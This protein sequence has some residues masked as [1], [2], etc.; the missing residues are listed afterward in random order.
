MIEVEERDERRVLP[1]DLDPLQ[2][3]FG[4]DED[5]RLLGLDVDDGRRRVDLDDRRP[6][7]RRGQ[8]LT[9]P[10]D[11]RSQHAQLR[12]AAMRAHVGSGFG[13]RADGRRRVRRL[14]PNRRAVAVPAHELQAGRAHEQSHP[15]AAVE[16]TD[17]GGSGRVRLVQGACEPLREQSGGRWLLAPVDDFSN[18]SLPLSSTGSVSIAWSQRQRRR[19]DQRRADA[20]ERTGEDE[21]GR[22]AG[23]RRGS[24][25]GAEDRQPDARAPL[26]PKRSPRLPAVSSRPANTSV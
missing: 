16:H 14:I 24:G 12:P 3:R 15:T 13:N 8:L 10:R 26:R 6:R 7:Q 21:L 11:T 23:E 1:A 9:H 20:H 22:R 25:T 19:H 4:A 2:H 18:T 5:P 17:R